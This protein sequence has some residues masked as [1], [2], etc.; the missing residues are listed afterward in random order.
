MHVA[1]AL[2][3]AKLARLQGAAGTQHRVHAALDWA[4]ADAIIRRHPVDVVVV[5]PHF[6]AS[7]EPR[8][9]RIRVVRQRYRSLPMI[10][11]SVLAAQTLRPLAELGREGLEELVLYG[12]DDDPHHLRQMLE[13]QPGIVL[14]QRLLDLLRVPLSGTPEPVAASVERLIRN[15]AA[16]RHV[17]DLAAAAGVPRRSLYRHL[18]RA[19]LATPREFLAG[20]RL[21][22]AYAFLRE[23]SY[24]LAAVANHVRFGDTDAMSKAMKWSAGT[25][26]GRARDRM[27][28]DEFL[29]RLALRLAPSFAAP[30]RAGFDAER[31][32]ASGE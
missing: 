21:L 19:G 8:A 4:H 17:P 18:E 9:D 6:D 29:D 14:S 3:P 7:N 11:Y 20:A 27:G 13:R 25:T 12:L 22:R 15:P 16:F 26:P 31:P 1:A 24:S 30:G 5:D 23:P 10:V 2:Q 32:G 28:P